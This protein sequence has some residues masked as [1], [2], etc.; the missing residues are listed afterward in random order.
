M[1]HFIKVTLL[2]LLTQEANAQ[3]TVDL[4]SKQKT[5]FA[6]FYIMMKLIDTI[7]VKHEGLNF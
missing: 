1:R 6:D 7:L 2:L 4:Q 3:I 5:E